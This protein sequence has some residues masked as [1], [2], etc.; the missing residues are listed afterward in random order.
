[1]SNKGVDVKRSDMKKSLMVLFILS[2]I[3]I[4]YSKIIFVGTDVPGG[5]RAILESPLRVRHKH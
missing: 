2:T 3:I 1:M 5:P 4:F